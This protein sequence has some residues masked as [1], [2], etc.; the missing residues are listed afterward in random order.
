METEPEPYITPEL[1]WSALG[2]VYDGEDPSDVYGDL[3][4]E[5]GYQDDV[6]DAVMRAEEESHDFDAC[7]DK[8]SHN[9]MCTGLTC[10]TL[11]GGIILTTDCPCKCHGGFDD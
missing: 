7:R 3:M 2:R 4:T 8:A 10:Q 9:W 6:T 5:A 11:P 1:V